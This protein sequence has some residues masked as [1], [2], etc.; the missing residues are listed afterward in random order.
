MA[1]K[2]PDTATNGQ[3]STSNQAQTAAESSTKKTENNDGSS[4][5]LIIIMSVVMLVISGLSVTVTLLLTGSNANTAALTKSTD[6]D[7]A[8][9]VDEK[10]ENVESEAA[11][12]QQRAEIKQAMMK[13][14]K[15]AKDHQP[16]KYYPIRPAMVLNYRDER[17]KMRFLQVAVDVMSRDPKALENVQSHL[18]RI[19][20]DLINL[21][22]SKNFAQIEDIK[23]RDSL[24]AEALTIIQNVL[25]QE[26]G[27]PGIEAVLFTNYVT[28]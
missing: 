8:L 1:G 2:K 20:N 11:A 4:K 9:A 10:E 6:A 13:K 5:K 14:K 28:Q 12:A 3:E 16:A 18:P 23:Q 27:D 26:S 24:R 19:Q 22:N 15:L 17:G 21:F 25:Y 7:L